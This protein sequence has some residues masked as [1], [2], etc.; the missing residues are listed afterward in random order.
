MSYGNS[1]LANMT[2]IPKYLEISVSQKIEEVL[3]KIELKEIRVHIRAPILG[4]KVDMMVI[5]Q[6]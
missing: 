4:E 6:N 5:F 1:I 2:T 3:K